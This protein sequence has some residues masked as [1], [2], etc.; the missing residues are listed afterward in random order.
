MT[1][2][3]GNPLSFIDAIKCSCTDTFSSACSPSF[4][5][6]RP[7][8]SHMLTPCTQSHNASTASSARTSVRRTSGC[9]PSK[10]IPPLCPS[11]CALLPHLVPDIP[12]VTAST[13]CG[14][15]A[16]LRR[17]FSAA[18]HRRSLRQRRRRNRRRTGPTFLLVCAH[19]KNL[20]ARACSQASRRARLHADRLVWVRH[21]RTACD[22]FIGATAQHDHRSDRQ[23]SDRHRPRQRY[24]LER[25]RR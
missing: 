24:T 8:R 4:T 10:R 17:S 13:P 7:A 18:L 5:A 21:V 9:P 3:T 12:F 22:V 11:P 20:F 25:D 1:E 19:C 2:I 14:T 16:A 6:P 23:Q 15:F